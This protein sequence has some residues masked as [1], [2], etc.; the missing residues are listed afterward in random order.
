[1]ILPRERPWPD[2][3][4]DLL[5][6]LVGF[7]EFIHTTAVNKVAG[8]TDEQARVT[9]IA[10][11]PAMS[12][13]GLLKHLT[14]VQRQHIQIHIGGADLPS[15]WRADDLEH[16]FRLGPDD[17]IEHVVELFDAEFER[18]RRTLDG[19]DPQRGITAYGQPNHAGRLLTDVLQEC[20]RHVGHMDII[21]ELIDGSTGE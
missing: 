21:R 10:T 18:S 11:S 6:S 8:L 5:G 20:A 19:L 14:A 7:L 16:E 2:R 12:L 13:L 3:Q 17:T 9:P 1:M 4:L 15:L